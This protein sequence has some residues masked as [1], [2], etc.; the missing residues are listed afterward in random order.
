MAQLWERTKDVVLG[1]ILAG[2]VWSAVLY[3]VGSWHAGR[4]LTFGEFADYERALDESVIS[5][6]Q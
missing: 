2:L 3:G 6:G 4:P 5:L 1:G